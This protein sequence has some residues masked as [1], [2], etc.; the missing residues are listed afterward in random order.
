MQEIV[1]TI[2]AHGGT[3][4]AARLWRGLG[5]AIELNQARTP[6]IFQ[7]SPRWANG[8]GRLAGAE[9]S[10]HRTCRGVQAHILQQPAQIQGIGGGTTKYGRLEPVHHARPHRPVHAAAGDQPDTHFGQAHL[11]P[12]GPDVGAIAGHHENRIRRRET[13]GVHGPGVGPGPV[14]PVDLGIAEDPGRTRGAGGG[15]QHPASAAPDFVGHGG[16]TAKG[17]MVFHIHRHFGF[18]HHRPLN[19]ILYAGDIGG[20]QAQTVKAFPVEEAILVKKRRHDRQFLVLDS[21]QLVPRGAIEARRP[22]GAVGSLIGVV[23]EPRQDGQPVGPGFFRA[24]AHPSP[25]ASSSSSR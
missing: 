11:H 21:G 5:T 1:F 15:K 8:H 12:P 13:H 6:Q 10:P 23:L 20:R 22:H 16:V 24:A 2:L 3:G 9:Q 18:I 19:Q 17:R 4:I 25:C 7:L 14:F